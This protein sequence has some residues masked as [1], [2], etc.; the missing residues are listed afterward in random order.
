MISFSRFRFVFLLLLP[1]IAFPI[2]CAR[3]YFVADH[4]FVLAEVPANLPR[5]P[6]SVALVKSDAM[7]RFDLDISSDDE[8]GSRVAAAAMQGLYD[9]ASLIV[10]EVRLVDSAAVEP[11]DITCIPTNPYISIRR[12]RQR[13]VAVSITLEVTVIEKGTGTQRGLLLSAEGS[14]GKR[15]AVP[16]RVCPPGCDQE[17]QIGVTGALLYYGT[18]FEQAVNNALFF[19]SLDFAE[20]LQKRAANYWQETH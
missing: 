4:P 1:M 16:I 10:S 8:F 14:A 12:D 7:E 11:A 19:L 2:G 5:I 13:R 3:R 20:K 18:Y 17:W 15:P 9:A 6:V